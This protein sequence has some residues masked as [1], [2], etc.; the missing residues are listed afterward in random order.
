MCVHGLLSSLPILLLHWGAL[1]VP[2]AQNL[3]FSLAFFWKKLQGPLQG[4]TVWQETCMHARERV[5][6]HVMPN[7]A[8]SVFLADLSSSNTHKPKPRMRNTHTQCYVME[9]SPHRSSLPRYLL[10]I[11]IISNS[12]PTEVITNVMQNCPRD[13]DKIQAQ[14]FAIQLWLVQCR[15]C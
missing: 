10:S 6:L 13:Q 5:C 12:K 15:K 8:H 7:L 1:I 11:S 3:V 2:T 14:S 4:E 9:K